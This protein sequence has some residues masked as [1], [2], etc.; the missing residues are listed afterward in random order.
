LEKV[1]EDC[2]EIGSPDVKV[3]Q[4]D[5][6]DTQTL[7]EFLEE[8]TMEWGIDLF[9]ANA[10][11]ASVANTPL[12]DRTEKILQINTIGAIAGINA[13]FKAMK[14]RGRGGQ[15]AAVSSVLGF[16]NPATLLGYGASK[17]A[18][19]SYCRDLRT[20][21][22]SDGILV[23]TIAP[24]YIQTPMTGALSKVPKAFYL[25]PENLGETIKHGLENDVAL[26]SAPLH[27][28]FVFGLFSIL[29]PA[30]K[31]AFNEFLFKYVDGRLYRK[32][33]E[34]NKTN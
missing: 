29:P 25:T 3:V 11:I 12:L 28:F 8:K 13:A 15:I 24:G 31:Y 10:G 1:A 5:V 23:N 27:Q 17:A 34:S 22:K 4:M 20:L 26:I 6:A 2:R 19:M 33:D 32:K 21:G 9:I 7:S 16:Y 18:V 30:A 14:K